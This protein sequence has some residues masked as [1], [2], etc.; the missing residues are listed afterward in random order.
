MSELVSVII[1]SYNRRH[2]LC[3]CID[4]VV[5]QASVSIE[6]IVVDDCSE[7]DTEEFLHLNYPDVRLISCVRRYGPS[8]LRN[9]GLRE[10]RGKFIL[11]LDSDAVLPRQDIVQRMVETLSRDRNTGEIG[12]EIPVYRNILDKAIGKRRDFF[13]K[14]HDVLSKK[15]EKAENQMK[16]CTYLATC[17]CMVRKEVAFEVGGFDPY[18]NFGG[19][20]ADFGLRILRSGYSNKIDFKVGVHHHRAILGRYPDETYRYHRTRVR[21]NLKHLSEIRNIIFFLMDFFSFLIFYL[22]LVPKILVKKINDDE[23]APE[24]Y[25][26][27]WYLMKAYSVNLAKHTEIKRQ[28]GVNFLRDEEIERFEAYVVSNN[29]ENFWDTDYCR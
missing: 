3:R 23:L 13:G 17:N 10:A 22:I 14:N 1:P 25:L 7:D 4:S 5:S 16:K 20:D 18:Y 29:L 2:D 15:G 26:G 11:F 27:G 21:F 8:H 28:R 6:I 19:E 9:L 24:N 12:G